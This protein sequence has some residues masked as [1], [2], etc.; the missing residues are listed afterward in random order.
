MWCWNYLE[1]SGMLHHENIWA[2]YQYVVLKLTR[3][4]R[5]ATSWKHTSSIPICGVETRYRSQECY[6]MK[7]YELHINMWCWNYLEKSGMLHHENIRAPYQYVV[8]KLAR[9]VRNATS[10]K[11]MSS[12]PI[13]GVETSYRS[14]ECYIM[15]TYELHTNMWCWN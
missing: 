12:I 1:K 5:N 2:P 13:C 3:E 6:I 14:Q 10:W 7:I 11:Y 9:E 15:K 4:V 8:L